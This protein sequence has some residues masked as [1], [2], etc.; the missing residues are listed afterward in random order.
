MKEQL[1]EKLK[2]V[3]TGLGRLGQIAEQNTINEAIQALTSVKSESAEE[4]KNK[5]GDL[6][7]GFDTQKVE[8]TSGDEEFNK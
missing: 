3:S 4:L 2:K 5:L 1:I 7:D 8:Y 6:V